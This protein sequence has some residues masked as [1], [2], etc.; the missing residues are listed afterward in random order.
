[1][2]PLEDFRIAQD[3]LLTEAGLTAREVR[4]SRATLAPCDATRA[5][6][7]HT[8]GCL[9]LMGDP[10]TGKSIG[11]AR[12]LLTEGLLPRNWH[13]FG[14]VDGFSWKYRGGRLLWRT[15]KSL[16]RVKQYDEAEMERLFGPARLV[17][18]DIGMEYLDA[19]GFLV[20]LIDEVI[21]ERHRRELPTVMTANLSP[22]EFI[23][24]YGGRVLDRISEYQ[25]PAVCRRK[26][27]RTTPARELDRTLPELAS[28]AEVVARHVAILEFEAL[29]D[30]T[31]RERWEQERRLRDDRETQRRAAGVSA[32]RGPSPARRLADEKSADDAAKE[33]AD[34]ERAADALRV[35]R[36]RV[37]A[38]GNRGES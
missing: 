34:T 24:R 9:L 16:S 25:P 14:G 7:G 27:F 11:A 2:T 28:D 23:E 22:A 38:A 32:I 36:D 5:T 12:W 33:A 17:I 37:A 8:A 1:M 21:H 35:L 30:K 20:S 26:S 6:D 10:G 31:D 13:G 29:R 3:K 18:D 4:E 19:K 15:A